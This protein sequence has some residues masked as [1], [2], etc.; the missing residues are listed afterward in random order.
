MSKARK[1]VGWVVTDADY[2]GYVT[3]HGPYWDPME[4]QRKV[5]ELT[6]PSEAPRLTLIPIERI[7][8]A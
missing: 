3:L 5:E 4:A 7:R 8:P 2:D 1:S 6:H